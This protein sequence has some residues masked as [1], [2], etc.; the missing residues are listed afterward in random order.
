M[1]QID[2][3]G[4]QC[5]KCGIYKPWAEFNKGMIRGHRPNCRECQKLHEQNYQRD[6]DSRRAAGRSY[7]RRTIEVRR[8][9]ARDYYAKKKEQD[10]GATR[11]SS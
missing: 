7:Y 9:Y 10:N 11:E 8:Q 3:T 2:E 6:L 5:S 1:S 4:R